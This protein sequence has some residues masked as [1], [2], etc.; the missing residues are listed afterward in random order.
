MSTSQPAL[1]ARGHAAV[2]GINMYYEVHGPAAGVPLVL[3]HGGGSTIEVT[4][5]TVLPLFARNRP[6]IAV[7]E[8]GHGRTSDRDQPVTFETSADDVAALVRHLGVS[9]VDVLGFSNG[10]SVG[11]QV[12]IRHA[13]LVR[14][15]IFASAMTR[16]DGARPELWQFMEQATFSNMPQPL[17][18]AFLRV[19]ADAQQLRVMHDKDAERMRRFEDV[20]DVLLRD[21]RASVL[22][23]IGDRDIVTPAHAVTLQQQI[24][25]ARLLV[26]PAGHGDYLGEAVMT[27]RESRVP[28]LTAALIEQFLD[29][30]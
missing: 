28:E 15:L 25:G 22:I 11:L 2:N 19:N 9:H 5:A 27:Q 14:K 13:D 18:D 17:K 23:L 12:A 29:E 30:P 10:A 4:F 26:L 7:E 1:R 6:V 3:L 20:P 24:P 16:R 8:Q 21:I